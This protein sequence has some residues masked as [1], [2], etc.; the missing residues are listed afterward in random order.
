MGA[1]CLFLA[2]LLMGCPNPVESGQYAGWDMKYNKIYDGV[3]QRPPLPEG[4]RAD[5]N[6]WI[7]DLTKDTIK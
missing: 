5:G 6:M 1:V 3:P 4:W 7:N 2:M